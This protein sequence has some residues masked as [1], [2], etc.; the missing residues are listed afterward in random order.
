MSRASAQEFLHA[1]FESLDDLPPEFAQRFEEV[2]KKDD[3]DRSQAIRQ[4]FEDF[5]C[6]GTARGAGVPASD[7]AGV[8][9]GA[10]RK[11]E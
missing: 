6:E 1:L 10:P 2:L 11:Y 9:G 5:A 8:W 3:V 4:L 7:R